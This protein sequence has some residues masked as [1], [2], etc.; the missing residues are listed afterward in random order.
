[1]GDA[2]GIVREGTTVGTVDERT[3]LFE[4]GLMFVEKFGIV[5]ELI[6]YRVE[7]FNDKVPICVLR[8]ISTH[9]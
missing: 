9:I 1:M 4:C 5:A 2:F 6:G 7:T 8:Q 3:A